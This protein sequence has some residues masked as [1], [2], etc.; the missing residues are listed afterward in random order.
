TNI[1]LGGAIFWLHWHHATAGRRLVDKDVGEEVVA[2]Y[3]RGTY[4]IPAASVLA[5]SLTALNPRLG[6]MVFLLVPLTFI[7]MR[8][9]FG[10][11]SAQQRAR[12]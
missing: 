6:T 8:L 4:V 5:M 9:S 7:L 1:L 3:R 10:V 12:A 2:F 11:H